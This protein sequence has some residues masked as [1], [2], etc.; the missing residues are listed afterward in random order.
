MNKYGVR[1]RIIRLEQELRALKA[2]YRGG[3]DAI[4][5]KIQKS[6]NTQP[7]WPA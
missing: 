2:N 7:A 5:F 6:Q 3:V 4:I 1:D